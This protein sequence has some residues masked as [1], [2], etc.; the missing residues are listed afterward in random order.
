MAVNVLFWK[1]LACFDT[2]FNKL[3]A[4]MTFGDYCHTEVDFVM[5]KREW[6]S[7]L[8]SFSVGGKAQRRSEIVWKR[9]EDLLQNIHA[10]TNIHLVFY[11]VWGSELNIRLLTAND[12]YVFNRLPDPRYTS[13]IPLKMDEEERRLALGFCFQ[14]LHKKYDATKAAT[15][16]VPRFESVCPRNFHN[17]PSKYFCSEFIVYMLQQIRPIYRQYY[18]ENVTPNDLNKIL[19][20]TVH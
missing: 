13:T 3:V 6:K 15:F 18:P 9:M 1:P 20:E 17:L 11:T 8:S 16:F 4:T 7:V 12:S 14:E 2:L 5:T 10:D 19:S